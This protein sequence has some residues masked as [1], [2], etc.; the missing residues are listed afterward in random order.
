M[1]EGCF[2]AGQCCA[3]GQARLAAVLSVQGAFRWAELCP[4]D[5]ISLHRQDTFL[6]AHALLS[7]LVLQAAVFAEWG[8][9]LEACAVLGGCGTFMEARLLPPGR[10]CSHGWGCHRLDYHTKNVC[11]WARLPLLPLTFMLATV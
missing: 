3:H 11:M 7:V 2:C 5:G 8:A 9:F 6:R 4:L 1:W 10:E